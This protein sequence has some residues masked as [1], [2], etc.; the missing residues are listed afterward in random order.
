MPFSIDDGIATCVGPQMGK[1]LCDSSCITCPIPGHICIPWFPLPD[2][3]KHRLVLG[4]NFVSYGQS[5]CI[6]TTLVPCG[7]RPSERSLFWNIGRIVII[8]AYFNKYTVLKQ[9]SFIYLYFFALS[10]VFRD[11]TVSSALL[12]NSWGYI[13]F[14]AWGPGARVIELTNRVWRRIYPRTFLSEWVFCHFPLAT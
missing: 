9:C 7:M 1:F 6:Y 4:H 12:N 10:Y 2:W 5:S 3:G 8:Y 14:L 13:L 11:A